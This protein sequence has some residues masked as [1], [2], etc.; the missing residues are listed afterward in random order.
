MPLRICPFFISAH[1]LAHV[2]LDS[3]II[4][5]REHMG[6][7]TTF[8]PNYENWVVPFTCYGWISSVVWLQS[9]SCSK[10][11]LWVGHSFFFFLNGSQ[12]SLAPTCFPLKIKWVVP[13]LW[14]PVLFGP[15]VLSA[16]NHHFG[17]FLSL[18]I[19]SS[20]VW[21]LSTF[22]SKMNILHSSFHFLWFPVLFGSN[23]FSTP[24][25]TFLVVPF[26]FH[27]S[28]CF[29]WLQS[30]VCSICWTV[31]FELLQ[32]VRTIL[33]LEQEFWIIWETKVFTFHIFIQVR[34]WDI[35]MQILDGFFRVKPENIGFTT[36][37]ENIGLHFA[38]SD[39]FH[40]CS[41]SNIFRYYP[42]AI[43]YCIKIGLC[44]LEIH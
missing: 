11:S 35:I 27:G 44:T 36:C 6:V 42:Q 34:F 38:L 20:V 37:M 13:F 12:C 33:D 32:V 8:L 14:F 10:S 19:V 3:S 2:S 7:A 23:M 15:K 1:W 25:S 16:Q 28:Q 29:F 4:S 26:T 43:Q 5:N 30:A 9:A 41:S 24:K 21:L 39:I 18:V 40:T 22:Y 17:W 31:E